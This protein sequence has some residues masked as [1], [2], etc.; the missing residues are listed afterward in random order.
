[1]S[2]LAIIRHWLTEDFVYKE[3]VLEFVKIEGVKSRENM[4]RIVLEL[5]YKLDIEYKLLSITIDNILN[6][7]TLIDT[8]ENSLQDRFSN[9]GNIIYT[10]CFHSQASYVRYLVYILNLIVKKLL[11][12]LKSGDRASTELVIEQVSKCQY[13][14]TTDSALA[15]L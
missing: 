1:M 2:I 8:I 6:N 13:L 4:S 12:T 3:T 9:L 15:R 10:L 11:K 7:K 5:L 14:N